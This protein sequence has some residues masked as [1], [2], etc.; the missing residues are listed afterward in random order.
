MSK[1]DSLTDPLVPEPYDPLVPEPYVERPTPSALR[2][3]SSVPLLL[4]AVVTFV[5]TLLRVWI[6]KHATFCGSADSCAYLA[7]GE[8]LSHHHGFV[9]RFLYEYQ[10]AAPHLPTHGI[11]YWRPG[12]SLILLAAQPFGGVTLFSSIVVTSLAAIVLALAAWKIAID[13]TRDR[14][15]AC[16]AYLLC[17][18]LPAVWTASLMPDSSIFYGAFAAWFL[19]LFQ[20]RFRSYLWDVIALLCVAGVNLIRNDT[21]LLLVPLIVVLW[22]RRRSG[23]PGGASTLYIALML[24]GFFAAMLPMVLIQHAVLGKLST[25]STSHVIY[26]TDLSEFL[27]YGGPPVS[28]HTMLAFGIV[29]LIKLRIVTLPLIVY[30]LLFIH[31]GFCLMFLVT[32]ANRRRLKPRANPLPE[33]AG[34]LSFSLAVLAMYGLVLPAIGGFSAIKSLTSI[35]PLAAVLIA[36]CIYN[37]AES[38]ATATTL[39]SMAVLLYIV[40]GVSLDRRDLT[41]LNRSGDSDRTVATYLTA[42]GATPAHTLVMIDDSALFSETT[43][44]AAIPV[45]S[46][47]LPATQAAI[48]DLHPDYILLDQGELTSSPAQIQST[49]HAPQIDQIPGTTI[50]ALTLTPNHP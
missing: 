2:K 8:S 16:A 11:E 28:L 36:V 6:A 49:L 12:V 19:A 31:I 34:G 32:L 7:L 15:I 4:A 1:G 42:H 10:F 30:H 26:L 43:G 41:D 37:A 46:N 14:R 40:A 45:P 38:S 25:S 24:F 47:G 17:L 35:L 18:V 20:V 48:A 39:A 50:F 3:H 29:K 21:I 23:R 5:V 13:A 27:R 33:L 22:L 9:Q 44:Y